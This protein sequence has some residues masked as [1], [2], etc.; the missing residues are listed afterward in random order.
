LVVSRQEVSVT[1][2]VPGKSVVS[3]QTCTLP[4]YAKRLVVQAE[5]VEVDG[6]SGGRWQD[7]PGGFGLS[8]A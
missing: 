2:P 3:L 5:L 8:G 7:T 1:Q 4:D 6:P